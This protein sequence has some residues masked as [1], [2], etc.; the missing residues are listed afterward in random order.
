MASRSCRRALPS[1]DEPSIPTPSSSASS[2]SDT[3]I[4][5]LFSRPSTSTN[6]SRTK[7]TPR[8]STVRSTYSPRRWAGVMGMF[9]APRYGGTD[10]GYMA[11]RSGT[12]PTV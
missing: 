5:K 8:S 6:H 12:V 9:I 7:R 2:S 1:S 3:G 10:R 4:A 11:T